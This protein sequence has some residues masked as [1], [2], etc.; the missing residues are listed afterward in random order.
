MYEVENNVSKYILVADG[1]QSYSDTTGG[2]VIF[3]IDEDGNGSA[4]INYTPKTGALNISVTIESHGSYFTAYSASYSN[5]KIYFYGEGGSSVTTSVTESI[6]YTIRY[7]TKEPLFQQGKTYLLAGAELVTT[8]NGYYTQKDAN[9]LHSDVLHSS[10]KLR[11]TEDVK[12]LCK[13]YN[14]ISVYEIPRFGAK[15]H[16]I[17]GMGNYAIQDRQLENNTTHYF[18]YNPKPG[19]M[20]ISNPKQ[21][22]FQSLSPF[23]DKTAPAFY[24]EMTLLGQN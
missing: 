20:T 17:R 2:S 5:N 18:S 15:N 23:Y 1:Q 22:G 14:D 11:T 21:W 10:A 12:V 3:R 8:H 24:N 16:L 6:T 13:L 7:V 4:S 9:F 19:M